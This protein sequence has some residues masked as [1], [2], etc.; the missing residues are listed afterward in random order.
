MSIRKKKIVVIA[1][2]VFLLASTQVSL[3]GAGILD[4]KVFI[5]QSG[6]AG[7]QASGEDTLSFEDGKLHSVEC[8]QWGFNK[9]VYTTTMEGSKILFEAETT[10]PENGKIMWKGAVEGNTLE[11]EYTWSKKRLLWTSK[12]QKWFKGSLKE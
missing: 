8:D 4:G 9:G 12:K 1:I 5:G 6:E 7:K 10:S 11:A 3:S 2:T